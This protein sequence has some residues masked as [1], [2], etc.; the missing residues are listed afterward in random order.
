MMAGNA[1]A[2]T[3]NDALSTTYQNNPSLNAA[4]AQL[5]SVDENVP[6]ALSGWRPSIFGSLSSGFVNRSSTG[7]TEKGFND[8]T[9]AVQMTQPLFRGFRT[10]NSTRQAEAIVRSQ[11]EELRT[12]EQDVL[13]Q[14]STAYMDVIRDTALV[15]LRRSDL[16]FQEENLRAAQD[17]FSVGEGTRTDV[18]QSEAGRAR[19]QSALNT[20]LANL[21]TSRAVFRQVIGV[22][23]VNLSAKTNITN[24]LPRNVGSA[25]TV[26]QEEHPAILSAVNLVDA[27]MFG[28]KTAE[29]RLLPTLDL[30]GNL[31]H[32]NNTLDGVGGGSTN[33]ASV[34]GRMT[35]PIYQ[36]GAVSSTIRQAKEELS[37]TQILVDVSRDTIR[38]RAISA[39]GQL[40]ASIASITAAEAEVAAARLALEGVIEEQRVG[41]RT[42][43]DV[44]DSQSD[45]I[46]ARVTLVTAQRDRVVAA[47]ALLSS[48]GR[49]NY[50]TLGLTGARYDATEH[51]DQVRDKWFGLRTPDGR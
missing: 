15:S 4:R 34:F 35:V 1:N 21:N 12:T 19:A 11:R 16:K 7:F 40:N 24:L 5:R 20:A 49:L 13:F 23:P 41:Q 9:V 26:G 8:T 27:A 3:I 6:Q 30:E 25:V 2:L 17:R 18:S 29:G 36:A 47:Y 28:V 44:L 42:T 46:N 39:W 51:Y 45:L 37:Q 14:A 32:N 33:T 22:D 43:L 10:V 50:E 38:A 48:V 31:S